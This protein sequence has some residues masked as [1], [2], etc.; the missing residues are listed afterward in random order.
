MNKHR[1]NPAFASQYF[2]WRRKRR[3]ISLGSWSS[4]ELVAIWKWC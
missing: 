3:S 2:E 4:S 1:S